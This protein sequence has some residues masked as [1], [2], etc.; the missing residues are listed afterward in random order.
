MK[1]RSFLIFKKIQN[2]M[3]YKTLNQEFKPSNQNNYETMMHTRKQ[4]SENQKNLI[5]L[6]QLASSSN[7][8]DSIKYSKTAGLT[9][10][11]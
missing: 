2:F 1:L 9:A 6:F 3:F 8:K 5:Y 7:H 11:I 10:I 4:Q